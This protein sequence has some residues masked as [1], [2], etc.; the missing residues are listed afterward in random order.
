LRDKITEVERTSGSFTNWQVEC[1]GSI[2]SCKGY[3]PFFGTIW[4]R[5]RSSFGPLSPYKKSF[6]FGSPSSIWRANL[7]IV[8]VSFPSNRRQ[9]V[10]ALHRVERLVFSRSSSPA[11]HA[12][13]ATPDAES[14]ARKAR[15]GPS[16][17]AN[18]AL[19]PFRGP[20][21][22]LRLKNLRNQSEPAAV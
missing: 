14:T 16:I 20:L 15:P 5:L 9:W 1:R 19:Q 12:F 10:D 18:H 22:V 7:L 2:S 11:N 8:S 6:H 3:T 4:P 13:L 17:H 21:F